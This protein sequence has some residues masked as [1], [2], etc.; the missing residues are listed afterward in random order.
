MRKAKNP[1]PKESAKKA[2]RSTARR[3]QAHTKSAPRTAATTAKHIELPVVVA[4]TQA[5]SPTRMAS[6]LIFWPALPIAMMRM[7]LGPRATAAG[8]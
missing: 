1:R 7:W 4:P 6:P 8:K 3:R 2:G 5:K